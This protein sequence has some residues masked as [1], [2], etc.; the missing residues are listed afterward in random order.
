MII[1]PAIS[2]LFIVEESHVFLEPLFS[3]LQLIP[4]I[5]L[6]TKAHLPEEIN[7]YNVIVTLNSGDVVDDHHRLERFVQTGGGWLELVH[8]SDSPLPQVFGAQPTPLGP[9]T[10]LRVMFQSPDNPLS[11]R[12]PDA[13][14]VGGHYQSLEPAAEDTHTLLYTDWR[15][16]HHAVLMTREVGDGRAACTTPRRWPA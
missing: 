9:R 16:Q 11:E 15:Y 3:Y 14:Y 5:Q 1:Q 8:L 12:W 6:T 2:V 7:S 4:S 13:I 10:D